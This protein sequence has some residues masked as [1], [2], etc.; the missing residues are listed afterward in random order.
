MVAINQGSDP[1]RF[2]ANVYIMSF[3]PNAGIHKRIA[4]E[5][6]GPAVV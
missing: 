1:G 3:E 4:I 2:S 5:G 6:K